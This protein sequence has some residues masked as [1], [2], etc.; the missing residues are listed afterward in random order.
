MRREQVLQRGKQC[1]PLLMPPNSLSMVN[2]RASLMIRSSLFW[3]P[4]SH[5]DSSSRAVMVVSLSCVQAR[6]ANFF[7]LFAALLSGFYDSEI[8]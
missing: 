4:P 3:L 7:A 1:A 6:L 2:I 8:V 5:P